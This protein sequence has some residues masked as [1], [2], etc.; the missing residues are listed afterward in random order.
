MTEKVKAKGNRGGGDD[1]ADPDTSWMAGSFGV[2]FHWTAKIVDNYGSKNWEQAVA[3]FNVKNFADSVESFGA[4]HVIFTVAHAWQQL[5]CPCAALDSYIAGRTTPRD[6][7]KDIIDELTNR[8]IRVV[9]YYNHSCNH[10]E[11]SAWQAASGYNDITDEASMAAF[12][13]KI[14]SIVRELSQRYGDGVSAWW[15]DSASSVDDSEP[16]TGNKKSAYVNG[17]RFPWNDL[18]AAARA[19]NP[20]AAVAVNWDVGATNQHELATDYLSGE[21]EKIDAYGNFFPFA[22][23]ELQDHIWTRMD[24]SDWFWQGG[25]VSG[26]GSRFTAEQLA[27]W[28]ASHRAAGR[29]A[30]LNLVIDEAGN[31]N[32]VVAQ[33]LVNAKTI[34]KVWVQGR[35]DPTK[36]QAAPAASNLIRGAVGEFTGNRSGTS[37]SY[38]DTPM[39]VLTDGS[40][41]NTE[42]VAGANLNSIA[43]Q[44]FGS[45]DEGDVFAWTLA[46]PSDIYGL[47]IYSRSGR[48]PYTGATDGGNDAIVVTKVEVQSAGSSE[49]TDIGA[50]AISFGKQDGISGGA[51]AA[52]LVDGTGAPLATGV[53][54]LRFTQGAPEN[55]TS[56]LVECEIIGCA[57]GEAPDD[58]PPEEPEDDDP[59][60]IENPTSALVN[61]FTFNLSSRRFYDCI[62]KRDAVLID[63]DLATIENLS[64]ADVPSTVTDYNKAIAL[65]QYTGLKVAHS[66]PTNAAHPYCLVIRF[67]SPSA[68]HGTWRALYQTIQENNTDASLF[69]QNSND[70]CIGK[71]GET[72]W[73]G[74]YGSVSD[75]VW[76]SL[77]VS[78]DTVN[79]VSALYLDGT[80]IR[81]ISSASGPNDLTGRPCIYFGLDNDG[82]DNTLY[83]DDIRIYNEAKPLAVFDGDSVRA[84]G[85]DDTIGGG[86]PEPPVY[87]LTIP[88]RTGLVLDSV[89][90]NGTSVAGA[91]GVYSVVSNTEVTITF[92]AADGYELDGNEGVVTKTIV[93]NYTFADAD[94]PAVKEQGGGG[95]DDPEDIANPTKALVNHFTFNLASKRYYDCIAKRDAVMVNRSCEAKNVDTAVPSGVEGASKAI[96]I[97]MNYGLR[98][99]H[100]IPTDDYHSYCM[101][102]RFYSPAASEGNFRAFYQTLQ[103]NNDDAGCFIGNSGKGDKIGAATPW[104]GYYGNKVSCDAWHTFILSVDVSDPGNRTKSIY[105]DGTRLTTQHMATGSQEDLQGRQYIFV[106]L[107]DNGEDDTLYFDDIRIYNVAKPKAVFDGD[108]VRENG[109]DDT[110]GEGS[111]PPPVY[112]LTIPAKM[113]LE[114]ASVKTNDVTIAGEENVY[115]IVSNTEVTITFTAASGYELDGNDGMVVKTIE[116]NYE[117]A[118]ADYPAVKEQGG[119]TEDPVEPQPGEL[120]NGRA[121]MKGWSMKR[122]STASKVSS[123]TGFGWSAA[124]NPSSK[125]YSATESVMVFNE[126]QVVNTIQLFAPP[127]SKDGNYYKKK[128]ENAMVSAFNVYGSNTGSDWVSLLSVTG[129]ADWLSFENRYYTFCNE[130]AYAQYKLVVVGTVGGGDPKLGVYNYFFAKPADPTKP[131][132]WDASKKTLTRDDQSFNNPQLS[133]GYISLQYNNNSGTQNE[134]LYDLDFSAG[135]VDTS[136]T[137]MTEPLKIS[138]SN[139]VKQNSCVTRLI[140]GSYPVVISGDQAFQD[141]TYLFEAELGTGTTLS[142]KETFKQCYSLN[143]IDISKLPAETIDHIFPSCYNLSGEM[144][145]CTSKMHTAFGSSNLVTADFEGVTEFGDGNSYLGT[146]DCCRQLQKIVLG[147]NLQKINGGKTFGRLK[148]SEGSNGVA[149]YWKSAPPEFSLP[150]GL[151]HESDNNVYTNYLPLTYK[152]EWT[153]F[154]QNPGISNF[155]LVLPETDDGVGTWT[156]GSTQVVKWWNDAPPAKSGFI[157]IVR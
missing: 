7:M 89:K 108:N 150:N 74:Y 27:W 41:P 19:G 56:L 134:T 121:N 39:S 110:I 136:G 59:E 100:S 32:P 21:T 132:T 10:N 65:P 149:I 28:K 5:P 78:V 6:L 94:Y 2:S 140:V 137:P 18:F 83:F 123:E 111:E 24:S 29:M 103:T 152:A 25:E 116:S 4:Q 144:K 119:G 12:G 96:S 155:T 113:G 64:V 98:V 75:D 70:G 91:E 62:A 68:S 52:K 106:S 97:A 118:A 67:Y 135:V 3:N 130:T 124:D 79:S 20:H 142:G 90:T 54:A 35:Y 81:E 33:Q 153:A 23:D 131:W 127:A 101:V 76:H 138:N 107:D 93:S 26:Y 105:L 14:C 34:G 109:P 17:L 139:G 102:M 15:F 61:H 69:L 148:F 77:V 88:A 92:A 58:P 45:K 44:I 1:K 40:V 16:W 114:L 117:F 49:W 42:I 72:S 86:D 48:S 22:P 126:A 53:K 57:A 143:T 156:S 145:I 154:A 157:L 104:G 128:F 80:K 112:T 55:N 37:G 43:T 122:I 84:G 47:N 120:V 13:S 30:T 115:S 31:I 82:E 63:K 87:S 73:R 38:H 99:E 95:E 66:I 85:P 146:F 60:D 36:W 50:P 51:L 125:S 133:G 129:E 9:F 147:S 11:D 151:F 46:E 141:L 8:N 71:S